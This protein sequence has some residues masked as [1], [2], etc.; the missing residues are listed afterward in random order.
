M[1]ARR[2]S[3]PVRATFYVTGMEHSPTN[4]TGAARERTPWLAVQG[5]VRDALRRASLE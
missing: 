5:A 2:A 1:T 4:A 3:P